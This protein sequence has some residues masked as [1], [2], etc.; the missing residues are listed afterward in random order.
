MRLQHPFHATVRAH[1]HHARW[2]V[3]LLVGTLLLLAACD[4]R[5]SP[6]KPETGLVARLV[7]GA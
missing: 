2:P 7:V 6:P 1:G 4:P 3:L 5:R